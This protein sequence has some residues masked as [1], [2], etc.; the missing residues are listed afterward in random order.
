MKEYV[1]EKKQERE[2]IANLKKQEILEKVQ[3]AEYIAGTDKIAKN[4]MKQLDMEFDPETYDKLMA[5]TFNEDYYEQDDDK[6]KVFEKTAVDDYGEVSR[7]D[8]KPQ[9]AKS[10]DEGEQ[11]DEMKEEDKDAQPVLKDEQMKH[12]KKKREVKQAFKELEQEDDYDV[13]YACDGCMNAI[14][15]GKFRFDCKV[16]DNFTFCQK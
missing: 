13:W 4:V 2:Q 15:P 6:E 1:K 11:D 9:P 3:E 8:E 7:Y 12:L 16:C 14:K 10:L 5:K